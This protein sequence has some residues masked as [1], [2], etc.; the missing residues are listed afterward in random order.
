M[1]RAV[2]LA[3][4]IGAAVGVFWLFAIDA[5][6]NGATWP[7]DWRHW[8]A[9]L[10]CPFAVFVGINNVANALVPLLNAI[11]YGA[12]LYTVERVSARMREGS[13]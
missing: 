13:Q 11:Y 6:V 9:R 8:V 1:R 12:V 5:A 3:A 2:V 7:P 10:T 4:V